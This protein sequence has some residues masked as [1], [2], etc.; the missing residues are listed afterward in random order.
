MDSTT[1]NYSSYLKRFGLSAFRPGQQKVVDAVYDGRDCL[2]IMP[3]GGGKS[4]CFQL[5]AIARSGTVLVVSPLIALMKD[6]VDTLNRK[7]ISATCINS[8]LHPSEQRDRIMRMAEGQFD[9]V[10]IA[11]ERMKSRFFVESLAATKV[12]LLAID[13]AHCISQWGHDFRPDYARLGRLRQE[14][15]APQ[16]I[17]LTATATPTVRKDI[18]EVLQLNQPRVFVSG[19][20]RDNLSLSVSQPASNSDKDEMLLRFIKA[21]RGAGIVYSSTR[22]ACDHLAELLNRKLRRK[23]R[24]YHAGLEPADRKKVQ[25][26]FSAGEIDVMVATNAFGMGIDKSD[27]RF[28]VH[29]NMPGSI[30]AYYQEAGRAGRAGKPARCELLYSFQDRFIQEFFIDNSYPTQEIVKKVY[31]YL[32]GLKIDP[33]EMT[34]QELQNELEINV[35]TE[36]IRVSEALLHKHGAIER[37]DSQQNQA[38]VK[39]NSELPTIVDLLPRE[40]R[41]R[42]H[43]LR[44]IE[45]GMKD[46]RGERVYFSPQEL[47]QQTEMT[48][49]S[50]Q[51]CL[52]DLNKLDC[53]DYVPPFRG[54]AVHV[55]KRVPFDD[56]Q[57]DFSELESRKK[58]EMKRLESVISF[59][60]ANSCRQLEILEYF[61]DQIQRPCGQC[62]NCQSNSPISQDSAAHEVA[63][64]FGCL[65]ALQVTLSGIARTQ[66]R[67]GKNVA[68]QMLCGSGNK[69][70]KSM[71]LNRL[72]TFGLLRKLNQSQAVSLIDCLINARLV[73]QSEQQKFRPLICITDRGSEVMRGF[74]LSHALGFVPDS[75]RK[76]MNFH[77]TNKQPHIAEYLA[78]VDDTPQSTVAFDDEVSD[79]DDVEEFQ[80]QPSENRPAD[81]FEVSDEI[82][83]IAHDDDPM[84]VDQ[85][86]LSDDATDHSSLEMQFGDVPEI[87]EEA[88]QERMRAD[89][90]H[91]VDG[92]V[93]NPAGK[94]PEYYWTWKLFSLGFHGDEVCQIRQTSLQTAMTHLAAAGENG[95]E[96]SNHWLDSLTESDV[97]LPLE[98]R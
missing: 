42:R 92:P 80:E 48:W 62:D 64:N 27:L 58:E 36:G 83:S 56:L 95:L 43:V 87:D 81:P 86:D 52:R 94:R 38:S 78:D 23:V 77:F 3:T 72:S 34:L 40:A 22:K 68:A 8:S 66:G 65:Y 74:N 44:A 93:G 28:V 18:C 33:I 9:L 5:P 60:T 45:S 4:L 51:R 16:T 91:A 19:F 88:D 10:Y 29:Y 59:A 26:A 70:M 76:L 57:I 14:I 82:D 41:K 89:A 39:I 75:I 31:E 20:A 69:K 6:Q 49:D 7:S 84:T 90:A 32:C 30:E 54:R 85:D 63:E 61:G 24:V 1:P 47:C 50:V 35:G 53:F 2:C 71:G 17:A 37:L 11:P 96:V 21:N 12:Q 13:E 79:P 15:G 73:I 46:R 55:V 67:F 25:E 98:S 97:D